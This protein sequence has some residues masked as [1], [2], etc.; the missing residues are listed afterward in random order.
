MFDFDTKPRT[1]ISVG[2][3]EE[4]VLL[5]FTCPSLVEWPNVSAAGDQLRALVPILVD[6]PVI[7]DF[8]GVT[9]V[10]S[11]MIGELIDFFQRLRAVGGGLAVYVRNAQVA[12]AFETLQLGNL[13]PIVSDPAIA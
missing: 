9:N 4:A 12:E 1:W 13:F 11:A 2:S 7:I 6:R 5:S 10:S 3:V 8:N